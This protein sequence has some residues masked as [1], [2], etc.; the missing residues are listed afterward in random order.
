MVKWE[1]HSF[2]TRHLHFNLSFIVHYLRHLEKALD[3]YG[4]SI[5]TKLII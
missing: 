5:K 4:L 1:K 3:L 2:E